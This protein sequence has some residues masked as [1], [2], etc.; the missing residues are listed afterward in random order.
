[1]ESTIGI[2]EAKKHKTFKNDCGFK[3]ATFDPKYET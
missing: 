2:K 1:M 3:E